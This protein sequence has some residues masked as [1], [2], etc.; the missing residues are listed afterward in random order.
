MS[1]YTHSFVCAVALCAGP[2]LSI[3]AARPEAGSVVLVITGPITDTGALIEQSGG[4]MIG[5][6]SGVMGTLAVSHDA[7]FFDRLDQNGAWAVTNGT[8]LAQICGVVL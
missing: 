8:L 1:F 2:L 3:A 5:P 4:R 7:A 6:L